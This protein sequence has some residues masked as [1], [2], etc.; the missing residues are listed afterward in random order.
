MLHGHQG[1]PGPPALRCSPI[2]TSAWYWKVSSAG[3]AAAAAHA[4]E[5]RCCCDAERPAALNAMAGF[6]APA[7]AATP[8][9]RTAG[10]AAWR[11][12]LAA[13]AAE[14]PGLMALGLIAPDSMAEEVLVDWARCAATGMALL[15]AE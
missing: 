8:A 9:M 15:D 2:R 3:G 4:R 1:G 11:E 6:T 13:A 10:A 7:P 14:A 12:A 5:R